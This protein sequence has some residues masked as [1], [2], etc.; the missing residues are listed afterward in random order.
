MKLTEEDYEY[1]VNRGWGKTLELRADNFRTTLFSAKG[2]FPE[3]RYIP[4]DIETLME[5]T[6]LPPLLLPVLE[7]IRKC[8]APVHSLYQHGIRSLG[9]VIPDI[10]FGRL[11]PLAT[12]RVAEPSRFLENGHHDRTQLLAASQSHEIGQDVALALHSVASESLSVASGDHLRDLQPAARAILDCPALTTPVG[13]TV[14]WNPAR[15]TLEEQGARLSRKRKRQPPREEA[16]E[17]GEEESIMSII[18]GMF[19]RIEAMSIN[20]RD[21]VGREPNDNQ[22][23]MFDHAISI[24]DGTD[25]LYASTCARNL[26]YANGRL[27]QR[28]NRGHF[29]QAMFD[30]V[31]LIVTLV[32]GGI[33]SL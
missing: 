22:M 28:S 30:L 7:I 18:C 33:E 13:S 5:R 17:V 19:D 4:S 31:L 11:A 24:F 25:D 8:S 32:F 9:I 21:V 27:R 12:K 14:R 10:A 2:L 3:G 23:D 26:R 16:L 29:R 6:N 20:A 1:T 15:L